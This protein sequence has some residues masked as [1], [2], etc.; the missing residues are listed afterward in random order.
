MHTA[1]LHTSRTWSTSCL[2]T[3]A[4][5]TPLQQHGLPDHL[6]MCSQGGARSR[7]AGL[8]ADAVR[9]FVGPRLVTTL[10]LSGAAVGAAWLIWF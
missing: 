9:G 5:D 8:A 2:G 6:A 7:M 10:A 1:P 3:D 4:G